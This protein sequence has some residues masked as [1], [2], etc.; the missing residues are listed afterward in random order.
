MFP[1]SPLKT[2]YTV[3]CLA[4]EVVNIV[5]NNTSRPIIRTVRPVARGGAPGAYAP[6]PT[7]PSYP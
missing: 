7:G 5:T 4:E 1:T 3:T 6:P 2:G